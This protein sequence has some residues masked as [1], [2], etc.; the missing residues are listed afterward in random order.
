M[1]RARGGGG[2]VA[3]SDRSSPP[4]KK[5][6]RV[7]CRGKS[8]A[9]GVTCSRLPSRPPPP[10]LPQVHSPKLPQRRASRAHLTTARARRECGCQRRVRSSRGGGVRGRAVCDAALV[11][12][13][14]ACPERGLGRLPLTR[15]RRSATNERSRGT[16][17]TRKH[18]A[19]A[20]R[21]S[22]REQRGGDSA[23]ERAARWRAVRVQAREQCH[24]EEQRGVER[25][26]AVETRSS[27]VE[28]SAVD[29]RGGEQAPRAKPRATVGVVTALGTY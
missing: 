15:M 29:Q 4:P 8:G 20:G 13:T 5:K 2:T 9:E 16:W 24:G 14:R 6:P 27:A 11:A 18:T 3:T 23:V 25:S 28:I 7:T 10:P 22:V 12:Q 1:W 17:T 26:S 19:D 21:E